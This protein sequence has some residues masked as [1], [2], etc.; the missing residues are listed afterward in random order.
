MLVLGIEC[1]AH[2]FGIGI[3][4]A[5]KKKYYLMKNL[6]LKMMLEWI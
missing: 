5:K 2:T 1:T 4:D 3:I 6:N